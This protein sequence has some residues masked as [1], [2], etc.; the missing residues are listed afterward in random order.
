MDRIGGLAVGEVAQRSGIAVSAI[1]FYERKGLISSSRNSA[2]HR[3]YSPVVLRKIA[4]IQVAQRAGVPLRE[5][6]E[7]ISFLPPDA[8]V[9]VEDWEQ[10]SSNWATQLDDRIAR[11]QRLRKLMDGCIGCGCLSLGKCKLLNP[12]D[13]IGAN[14]PGPRFLEED[15]PDSLDF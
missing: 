10:L 14:G 15:A 6:A 8:K 4:I 9:T 13:M 3:R 1:H 2:N 11:L 12:D 7:A 5:I